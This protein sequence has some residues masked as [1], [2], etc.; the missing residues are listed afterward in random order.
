VR[1]ADGTVRWRGFSL[2]AAPWSDLAL[3]RLPAGVT[4]TSIVGRGPLRARACVARDAP[5]MGQ[6]PWAHPRPSIALWSRL[7]VCDAGAASTAP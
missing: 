6:V 4:L 5:Q 3:P 7:S 2:D 1:S